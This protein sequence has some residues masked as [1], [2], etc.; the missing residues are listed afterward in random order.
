MGRHLSVPALVLLFVVVICGCQS[1]PVQMSE[2]SQGNWRARAL[3]KDKEHSRS[4]IVNLDFN[5]VRNQAIRIDA[6]STLGQH[7]GSLVSTQSE[8]RY[9]TSDNKKFY[10]G[11]PRPDVLKPI[12]VLPLDPRWMENIL[13][14]ESIESADWTCAT[15][16]DKLV[17]QCRDDALNLVVKWENRKGAGRTVAISHPRAE[18]QINFREFTPKVEPLDHIFDLQAP[19]G[20]QKYK[21]R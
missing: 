4:F 10:V 16:D 3:I 6:T 13:F 1:K 18:I 17:S 20:Y 5:S 15:G 11:Q 21:V 9:Y 14:D 7:I 2:H 8:V 12:L 19:S